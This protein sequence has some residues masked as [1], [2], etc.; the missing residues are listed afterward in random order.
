MDYTIGVIADTHI[1]RRAKVI[2]QKVLDG[3]KGVNLIIH[4][5]DMLEDYIKY[6][7]EQIAPFEGVAGNNDGSHIR[8]MLGDKKILDI[9][10]VKIGITHGA[11]VGS[12][13]KGALKGA[14]EVFKNDK[15]DCVVFGH[16]HVPFNQLMDGV[17][18]FNP[19]SPTDKRTQEFYSFGML[20]IEN[21]SIRGDI[22]YFD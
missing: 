1:P 18:Y 21:G 8:D 15:V 4:A 5:G 6:E 2:P 11:G 17:L 14:R 20:Y 13:F 12:G 3:F 9:E 16:S 7:L 19:G 10:G 22:R